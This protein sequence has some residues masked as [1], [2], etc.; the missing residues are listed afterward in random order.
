MDRKI[1]VGLVELPV[2]T[3][4]DEDMYVSEVP[5]IHVASQGK[6]IEESISN[7]KEAVELYFED[8]DVEKI[9][10]EKFPVYNAIFTSTMAFDIKSRQVVS[11]PS[12]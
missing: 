1:N 9:I 8:E 6:T 10:K 2:V 5:F 12:E 3:Y 7:L 4:K 11:I